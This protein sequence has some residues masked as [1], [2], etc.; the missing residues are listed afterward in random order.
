MIALV[1]HKYKPI[2]AWDFYWSE[3]CKF[4]ISAAQCNKHAPGIV[5]HGRSSLP[6]SP[7]SAHGSVQ[8][9]DSEESLCTVCWRGLSQAPHPLLT[10]LPLLPLLQALQERL[11]P[12]YA[13]CLTCNKE[14]PSYLR[15]LD[16]Y[17][18]IPY[19]YC[20]SSS[21]FLNLISTD[22]PFSSVLSSYRNTVLFHKDFPFALILNS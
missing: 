3:D 16:Q 21:A 5:S 1:W 22:Y 9:W 13:R 14:S 7:S 4:S 18:L 8:F 10:A 6:L 17:I 20:L 11:R 15:N 12:P 19:R 2:Q